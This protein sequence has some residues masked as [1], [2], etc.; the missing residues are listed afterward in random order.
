ML[1]VYVFILEIYLCI[2][3]FTYC[4]FILLFIYS[5]S[6]F[7][8]LQEPFESIQDLQLALTPDEAQLPYI[9]ITKKSSKKTSIDLVLIRCLTVSCSHTKLMWLTSNQWVFGP[10]IAFYK[11]AFSFSVFDFLCFFFFFFFSI[12]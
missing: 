5:P 10:A 4:H 7:F 6:F 8:V 11:G 2:Y 1:F 12:I 9:V 3:L